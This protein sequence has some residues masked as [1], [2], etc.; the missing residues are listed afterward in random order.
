M[1]AETAAAEIVVPN[2]TCAVKSWRQNGRRRNRGAEMSRIDSY[3]F[4][5]G[6]QHVPKTV[7]LLGPSACL[8]TTPMIMYRKNESNEIVPAVGLHSRKHTMGVT[9]T[10]H[11]AI[12]QIIMWVYHLIS[13]PGISIQK[14]SF[15]LVIG[16]SRNVKR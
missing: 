4:R 5:L 3:M 10:A 16:I 1:E 7:E 8:A 2:S 13:G 11:D 6:C 15:P 9:Y 12:G 14:K